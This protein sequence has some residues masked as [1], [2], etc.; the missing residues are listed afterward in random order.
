RGKELKI[1]Y[2]LP[3]DPTGLPSN[4]ISLLKNAIANHTTVDVVNIMAMDYGSK[5]DM[6]AT[7]NQAA[8]GTFNQLKSLY[9]AKSTSQL[10]AMVGITPM[11]GVND[12]TSE[13]F[14]LSNAQT[15]LSFAQQHGV[16]LIAFWQTARDRQ[17]PSG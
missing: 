13:V 11:L 10:W 3:V 6:G 15:V 5:V 7:A 16:G 8:T 17:C 12:V 4:A 14:S 1:Q 9:P 2:T